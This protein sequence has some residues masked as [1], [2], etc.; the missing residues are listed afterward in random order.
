MTTKNRVSKA[1]VLIVS[2]L[3]GW[4]L[5]AFPATVSISNFNDMQNA[6]D[7]CSNGDTL[8]LSRDITM[9]SSISFGKSVTVLGNG[10]MITRTSAS[11]RINFQENVNV[12]DLVFNANRTSSTSVS[13]ILVSREGKVTMDL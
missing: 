2:M 13:F 6:L 12:S 5:E 4:I 10:H 11:N 8:S 9:S 3:F 1:I 7:R